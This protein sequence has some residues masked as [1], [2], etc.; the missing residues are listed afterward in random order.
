MMRTALF[1]GSA[2]ALIIPAQAFAQQ[3]PATTTE[4][5]DADAIIVTARRTEENLQDV[6]VAITAF[7]QKSLDERA[8]KTSFDLAKSVPG[9]VVNAG[10][11]N[12]ALPDFS[13]RGRGQFFGAASGS[14]ETYFADVPLSPPFPIPTLPPQYFDLASVQVLKGPQGTLFGRNTTGGAVLFVPQG[15]T[16]DFGGYVRAQGGN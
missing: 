16:K 9:L 2:L 7:S 1:A 3:V 5:G 10:S 15:P 12:A 6:P 4:A 13:I 11:G 8:I 14:V